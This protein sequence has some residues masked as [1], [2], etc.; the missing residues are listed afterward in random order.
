MTTGEKRVEKEMK[1]NAGRHSLNRLV[2]A[3]AAYP[4]ERTQAVTDYEVEC[5]HCKT[6]LRGGIGT[7]ILRLACYHCQK[8]VNLLWP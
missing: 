2:R 8:P 1:R 7:H 3:K 6:L 5:P 4:K